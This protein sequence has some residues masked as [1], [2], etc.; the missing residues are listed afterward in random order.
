[1][2]VLAAGAG[3]AAAGGASGVAGPNKFTKSS[4]GIFGT[5]VGM[6]SM[7]KKPSSLQQGEHGRGSVSSV[8]SGG[9]GGSGGSI[10]GGAPTGL[11]VSGL[12]AGAAGYHS[13]SASA[14]ATVGSRFD[15][16]LDNIGKLFQ[17]RIEFFG[18]VEMTRTGIMI[19]IIRSFIKVWP[20]SRK[21]GERRTYTN[22]LC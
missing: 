12:G 10:T 14:S 15:S 1:M 20:Y 9:A 17:E 21:F 7:F 4:S 2:S 11:G 5:A 6:G 13:R 22:S 3:G 18:T 16:M 8:F 19:C